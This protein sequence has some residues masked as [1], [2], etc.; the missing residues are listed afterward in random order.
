M[1]GGTKITYY[2]FEINV[3]GP[4]WPQY[5]LT[6]I[7]KQILGEGPTT[8]KRAARGVHDW[9]AWVSDYRRGHGLPG[10][11]RAPRRRDRDGAGARELVQVIASTAATD[12]PVD[13]R[14]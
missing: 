3:L 11:S 5:R 10:T 7:V 13:P 12:D 1:P 8:R 2:G 4:D 6:R 9:A 14:G